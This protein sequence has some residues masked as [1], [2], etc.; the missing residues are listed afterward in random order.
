MF[1]K[2]VHDIHV[3]ERWC[4]LFSQ[5][6]SRKKDNRFAMKNCE[7]PSL[8]PR[9]CFSNLICH[10][11]RH[12]LQVPLAL[13]QGQVF[14]LLR[15]RNVDSRTHH[16]VVDRHGQTSARVHVRHRIDCRTIHCQLQ[17]HS[18]SELQQKRRSVRP[19][20]HAGRIINRTTHGFST[21]TPSTICTVRS[22]TAAIL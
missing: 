13:F 7:T 11:C 20:Y 21:I 5:S 1:R 18:L 8:T 15:N 2:R 12:G 14:R 19:T 10:N 16:A 22:A 6:L 4:R 3:G 17:A 9:P